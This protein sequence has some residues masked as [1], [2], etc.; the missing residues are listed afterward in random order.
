MSNLEGECEQLFENLDGVLLCGVVDQLDRRVLAARAEEPVT[1]ELERVLVEAAVELL[2]RPSAGLLAPEGTGQQERFGEIQVTDL[3]TRYFVK[4]LTD[5]RRVVVLATHKD[6]NA[7]LG[8]AQLKS[9]A[10]RLEAVG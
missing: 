7:G 3:R 8:W 2:E 1:A 6:T 4:A 10:A 5:G 9:M